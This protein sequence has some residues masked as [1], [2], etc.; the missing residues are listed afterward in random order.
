MQPNKFRYVY[1]FPPI[2]QWHLGL[3]LELAATRVITESW[4]HHLRHDYIKE[5][6]DDF[7]LAKEAVRNTGDAHWKGDIRQGEGPFVI[8]LPHVAD[9]QF[10]TMA[11]KVVAFVWKQEQGGWTFV[12]STIPMPFIDE[13]LRS[14]DPA[15]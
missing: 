7:T 6:D 11:L 10:E 1:V 2:D 4:G 12:A 5:L 15:F 14:N 13:Y 3:P 8:A 9:T